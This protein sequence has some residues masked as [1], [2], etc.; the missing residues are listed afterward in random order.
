MDWDRLSE[1]W[2]LLRDVLIVVTALGLIVFEA[3]LYGGP[4]RQSLLLLYSGLLATP[5]FLRADNRRSN[6]Q[7]HTPEEAREVEP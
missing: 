2:P 3:V 6:G 4:V 7:P 5:I 1:R